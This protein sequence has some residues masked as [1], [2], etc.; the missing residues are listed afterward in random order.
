ME[1]KKSLLILMVVSVVFILNS[2][3]FGSD[4]TSSNPT[5]VSTQMKLI[6][7]GTFQM[8]S[9][10]N[11]DEQPVHSVTLTS[12]YMD[13]TEVT[14]ADYV[15][16]MGV[17]PSDFTDNSQWPV[18]NLSWFD[19]ALYCNAR[20]KR[21][22]RDTVYVYSGVTGIPGNRCTDLINLTIDL[23]KNGYR[24]PTEAQWE[25]ACRAGT[26]TEFYW[27]DDE[28]DDPT[29][30]PSQYSWNYSNASWVTHIV[31]QKVPNAFKLYDMTGN[32]SEWCND[33]YEPYSIDAQNNP[34][35]PA[36]GTAR[37]L[38]GGAWNT[39]G[40]PIGCLGSASRESNTPDAINQR[41]GFRC[42][43]PN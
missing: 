36:T 12:F 2:C 41:Y 10:I 7:S 15:A 6:P 30:V 28:S 24:L 11:D 1:L 38:R 40:N 31:A 37:V 23:S 5:K 39:P 19:A 21:D 14:Q 22:N 9:T 17:N 18:K 20:S 29:G 8:G 13:S 34:S 42:V 3:D 33:W 16:L 27:G 43:C 35:G 32:V 26:T 25:Y 4:P